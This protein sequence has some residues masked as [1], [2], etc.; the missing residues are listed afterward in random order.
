MKSYQY[1][2]T[3]EMNF[4]TN[5]EIKAFTPDESSCVNEITISSIYYGSSQGQNFMD[6]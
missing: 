5:T 1:S 4:T 6:Y 3:F 2:V